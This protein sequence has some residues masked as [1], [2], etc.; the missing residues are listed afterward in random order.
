MNQSTFRISLD[1]HSV[2]SQLSF[3][4][5]RGDNMRRLIITLTENGKPYEITDDCYAIFTTVKPDGKTIANDCVIKDNTIIYDFTEQTT[6]VAGKLDCSVVVFNTNNERITSPR[7][8]VIVYETN[9]QN[10][11]LESEDEYT[12][13]TS[14]INASIA[15]IEEM[16]DL[17]ETVNNER[18]TGVYDGLGVKNIQAYLRQSDEGGNLYQLDFAM[19]DGTIMQSSFV[20][21]R[22]NDGIGIPKGGNVGQVLTKTADGTTWAD[23]PSGGG[24]NNIQWL[25]PMNIEFVGG[26]GEQ[27]YGVLVPK[28]FTRY[29]FYL[30]K[31]S[32]EGIVQFSTNEML[33]RNTQYWMSGRGMTYTPD[34]YYSAYG[35]QYDHEYFIFFEYNLYGSDTDHSSFGEVPYVKMEV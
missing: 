32:Q 13:L 30:G 3:S 10:I 20:A 26:Y 9:H 4:V 35:N 1:V 18:E 34:G 7:F 17:I 19:T 2:A 8:T 11:N 27:H 21:P 28:G 12:I 29:S 23:A 31:Q 33:D 15:K 22:G 25:N 6:A 5:N 24:G 14:Q 16:D